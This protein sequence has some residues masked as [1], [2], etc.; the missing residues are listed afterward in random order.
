MKRHQEALTVLS[1]TAYTAGDSVCDLGF[2]S[3]GDEQFLDRVLVRDKGNHSAALDLYLYTDV[4]TA[5]S[6][7]SAHLLSEEDSLNFI[8]KI[9]FSSYTSE[10]TF[11]YSE[12]ENIGLPLPLDQ[13]STTN[14]YRLYYQ[15]KTTETPTYANASQLSID[16]YTLNDGDL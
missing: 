8:K 2:I 9:S 12:Q 11:S 6:A 5:T 14:D 15:V 4:V 3:L 1:N 7:G 16:F 13:N 10:T